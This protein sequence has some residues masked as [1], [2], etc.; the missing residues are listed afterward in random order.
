MEMTYSSL[1]I[2]LP[3]SP[4]PHHGRAVRSK[5]GHSRDHRTYG[6]CCRR[7]LFPSGGVRGDVHHLLHVQ[8][9]RQQ[10]HHVRS[11][12]FLVQ[13]T[14]SRRR[15]LSA[16]RSFGW[17]FSMFSLPS[18]MLP[19]FGSMSSYTLRI[20]TYWCLL[21]GTSIYRRSFPHCMYPVYLLGG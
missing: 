15:P 21:L 13:C 8:V 1:D 2:F 14:F 16:A 5:G 18:T 19:R 3:P 4:L 6:V 12:S 20:S 9:Q 10:D 7:Q 11:S 17:E